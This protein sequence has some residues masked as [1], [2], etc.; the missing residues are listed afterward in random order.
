MKTQVR[1]TV[2]I[3]SLAGFF[4]LGLSVTRH[5]DN[6]RV[7][8]IAQEQADERTN[9]LDM[10]L[11]LEGHASQTF[12]YDYSFWDDMV[13]FVRDPDSSWA[14][15][16][17]EAALTTYNS[18]A[19][20]V[21][22]RDFSPVYFLSNLDS[23]ALMVT[24]FS[25]IELARVFSR[26][27][28]CHF[29][30]KHENAL[31]EI[32]GAPIQPSSDYLRVS[33]PL[34]F[35]MVGKALDSEYMKTLGGLTGS[36]IAIR[37]D[38]E[39]GGLFEKSGTESIAFSKPL[40]SH[41]GDTIAWLEGVHD[42]EMLRELNAAN[43][44]NFYLLAAFALV[45]SAAIFALLVFWVGLPLRQLTASLRLGDE[46]PVEKL[47]LK[48]TEF[49]HLARLIIH[50]FRQNEE[51]EK[52]IIE[53]TKIE[54][55]LRAT[56]AKFTALADEQKVLLENARDFI[57]RHDTNGVFFYTSPSVTQTT[58]YTSEEWETHYT[59][60]LTDNPINRKVIEYTEA[61]LKSGQAHPPYLVE[62]YHKDGRPVL[63]E[64]NEQPYFERGKVAG[65][66]GVARDVTERKLIEER[67]RESE[68]K[69]R[70]LIE[71]IS[72]GVV[73]FDLQMDVL[74]ANRTACQIFGYEAEELTGMPLREIVAEEHY[75][76]M[77]R[78]LSNPH[79]KRESRYEAVICRKD[80]GRRYV[81]VAGKPHVDNS[82]DI[83]GSLAVFSDITEVK[84]AEEEKRVL[85]EKL[86]HA[87]KMESLAVLAGG[88]A[89]DLNNILGP[90]VAY[91]EMI[92]MG[93]PADSPLRKKVEMMGC[94]AREAADVIQDLLSLARRG[95][96]EMTS[97]N[98]ND[99]VSEFL[100]SPSYQ[101]LVSRNPDVYV[102]VSLGR[103]IGSICGSASHLLKV[104]MNLIINAFDAMPNGGRLL[105][106]TA[107]EYLKALRGGHNKIEPGDYVIFRVK[108]TG[109]G[110]DP[111][112]IRKI[113]EP[114]YSKKK[115]GSSGSGL[116]LSVVYGI[117]KDHKGYYDVLSRV[118][119]GTE[120]ILYFPVSEVLTETK[121]KPVDDYS[122]S[123]SI[124]VV[125]D[126]EEQR[127]VTVQLA[128][129]LGY[130]A[131]SVANGREAV[132]YLK[133]HKADLVIIDMILE[134]DFDGCDTF[135]EI[136]RSNPGQ[137][138]LIM[139]G[140]S[141]TERVELMQKMGA[142]QFVRK[143]F[144]RETLG[145]AIRESLNRSADPKTPIIA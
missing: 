54:K 101:T 64:V 75:G 29:Y 56:A 23:C 65:I 31:L 77:A 111:A 5:Y 53:R 11:E 112:D 7:E 3:L 35:L 79:E 96:Y 97:L 74:F 17:L 43:V 103:E 113:F 109:I 119:V 142:G 20:W 27:W 81:L 80:G 88:V 62:I 83:I 93:L 70:Y 76:K 22:G 127:E 37:L 136:I 1:L 14:R 10:V 18:N 114:Y 122:G 110:I 15:V 34:G 28:F 55:E 40:R 25:D 94:S 92:L 47:R 33:T 87:K 134:K 126:V 57:Y 141:A 131:A 144:N 104:V 50:Y 145:R 38:G 125:D 63:L 46:S 100:E 66:V 140:F 129:S 85:N 4:L 102:E 19:V 78:E 82:G 124:L 128:G 138:A 36:K 115:M 89:H 139:S 60:Y 120:F 135:R 107:Q 26:G 21:L 106:E 41:T 86:E 72:D 48:D 59:K 73:I 95:R 2:L 99:V 98:L 118:G 143:P 132:V 58:G 116:G 123:E 24:P 49:G 61:T 137:K 42:S 51:L 133:N 13:R 39:E 71:N 52:E 121:E 91:P 32:F 45:S 8:L 117:V 9:L 69:Y 105:I 67:L 68:E 16:N 30:L 130:K 84:Q 6:K 44:R 90:L 12:A 108:D